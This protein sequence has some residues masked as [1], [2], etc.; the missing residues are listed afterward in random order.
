MEATTRETITAAAREDYEVGEGEIR[1]LVVDTTSHF[2]KKVS[3]VVSRLSL[4]K[5]SHCVD[6][7]QWVRDGFDGLEG[8]ED[9]KEGEDCKQEEEKRPPNHVHRLTISNE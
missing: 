1:K 7:T 2:E 8:E 4:C 3:P 9:W 5:L 6:L